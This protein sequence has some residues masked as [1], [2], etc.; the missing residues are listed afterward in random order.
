MRF[1][2][3]LA[4]LTALALLLV[5]C[6]GD[7]PNAALTAE[8]V[9]ARAT[10]P[11]AEVGAVYMRLHNRGETAVR[12]VEVRSEVAQRAEVHTVGETVGETGGIMHMRAVKGGPEI[13]PGGSIE[14]RPGGM[15]LMLMGLAQPLVD[16]EHFA[17]TLRFDDGQTL[18]LEVPVSR[19]AP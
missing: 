3:V 11:G 12:L 10:P 18:R 16:G 5:A 15:H 19:E 4:A 13:P 14:L 6:N 2:P 7:A 9:W 17:I 1:P 8:Q